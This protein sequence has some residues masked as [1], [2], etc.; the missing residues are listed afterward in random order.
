MIELYVSKYPFV[1]YGRRK[2]M[3]ATAFFWLDVNT[4]RPATTGIFFA[5]QFR[6]RCLSKRW[7]Q[8]FFQ[9]VFLHFWISSKL[10]LF[11][12]LCIKTH[13]HGGK[14]LL[15]IISFDTH[16]TASFQPWPFFKKN[17]FFFKKPTFLKETPFF[18]MY[19]RNLTISVAFYGKSFTFWWFKKLNSKSGN[20]A[21]TIGK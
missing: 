9:K 12:F 20:S 4:R 15:K 16:S 14:E 5:L 10:K 11:G 19:L 21:R 13:N 8:L 2:F 1:V 7:K 3:V 6:W 17:L 18:C